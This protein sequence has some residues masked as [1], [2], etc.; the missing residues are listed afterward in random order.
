MTV[1]Q[2]RK[3]AWKR[4]YLWSQNKDRK[5]ERQAL[6]VEWDRL[7][8]ITAC[9]VCLQLQL[10]LIFFWLLYKCSEI[11][12]CISRKV[13][14]SFL[15]GTAVWLGCPLSKILLMPFMDRNSRRM[16]G[17][18]FWISSLLFWRWLWFSWLY[19]GVTSISHWGGLQLSEKHL[20]WEP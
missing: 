3:S 16:D 19:Q 17:V 2:Y 9:S 4:Y 5:V 15:V 12:V 10:V 1:W 18:G 11:L 20:G 6:S 14:D 13:S 8:A 7:C